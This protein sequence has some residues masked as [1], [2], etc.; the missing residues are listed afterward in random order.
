MWYFPL[1]PRLKRLYSSMATTSHVRW[2]NENQRDPNVMCHPSNGEAWKHFDTMH[3][4][5]SQDPRNVRL[6]LCSNGFSPIGQFGKTYSCWLIILTPYNLPSD[7]CMKR[8]F[9]FLTVLFL[10]PLDPRHKID[11]YLQPLIDDL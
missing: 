11:L 10:G 6:V 2:H 5:V 7:M 3:P 4:E 8:E 1:I 9:I